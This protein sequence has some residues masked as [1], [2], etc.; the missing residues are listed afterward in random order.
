MKISSHLHEHREL[1]RNVILQE[2]FEECE[3]VRANIEEFDN[4]K[5]KFYNS[6]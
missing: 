6:F 4:L 1:L 2:Q 5:V 3:R